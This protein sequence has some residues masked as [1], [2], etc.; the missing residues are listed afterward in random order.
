MTKKKIKLTN[1]DKFKISILIILFFYWV[2][3]K[4]LED[5]LAWGLIIGFTTGMIRFLIISVSYDILEKSIKARIITLIILLCF[6]LL[7]GI[8]GIIVSQL[9]YVIPLDILDWIIIFS[10]NFISILFIFL[11]IKYGKEYYF[12]AKLKLSLI[13]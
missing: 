1:K 6:S 13:Q 3:K 2:P 5:G 4:I 9:D 12:Q 10:L 8:G 7:F 11:I